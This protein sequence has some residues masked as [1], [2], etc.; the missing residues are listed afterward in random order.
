MPTFKPTAGKGGELSD[1][2]Q[3]AIAYSGWQER[4][5]RDSTLPENIASAI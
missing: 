4:E 1:R 3:P 5:G 2:L